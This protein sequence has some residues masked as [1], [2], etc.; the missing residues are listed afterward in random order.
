[1]KDVLITAIN[2]REEVSFTYSGLQRVAQP[3]AIGVS[4]K[5]NVIFRCYQTE[6]GHITPG[7]EWD[8]CTVAKIQNLQIMGK[9]FQ[10]N[11]AGYKR[12]DQ[13]MTQIY[14]QL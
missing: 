5:G 12:G 4:T 11:P 14:A 6:G 10:D 1:M 2:N 8:L 13:A 9:H 7:H 3:A